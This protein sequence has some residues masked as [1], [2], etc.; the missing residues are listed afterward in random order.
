MIGM[1]IMSLRRPVRALAMILAIVVAPLGTAQAVDVREVVSPGGITAWLVQ[2]RTVPV[3]AIEFTFKGAGSGFDPEGRE[4]TGTLLAATMDEGAGPHDSAAFQDLLADQS[5]SISFAAGRDSFSGSFYALNRY[6]DNAVELLRLALN[7]PRFDTEPV[8]RVRGQMIVGLRQDETDPGAIASR[9]L[10]ET[11]F[12]GHPYGRPSDGT[13]E[14]VAAITVEDLNA[15]R[16]S[17]LTKD[18][19]LIGVVGD[20]T[21]EEL[22][23]ILDTAFGALPRT[24]APDPVPMFEG[25]PPSGVVVADLDVPQSTIM[26]AQPGLAVDDPRYYAG[27]VLNQVLG[28]G[29]FNNRLTEEV[30]IKRGLAYSVYSFQHAMDKAALLR[31]GAGTQNA[32]VSET[33][34]VIRAVFAELKE[35]GIPEDRIADAKTFLTGS[36]P[37]RFT[38]SSSIAGQLAAMRYHGFGI[39]YIDTRNDILEAVT[40][41]QVNALAAELLDPEGLLF[42]VVGRPE[43][44]EATLP[45]PEG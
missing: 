6:R 39:D 2:D 36:Y 27:M 1:P 3:T 13:P 33:L 41:E 23:P 31:G 24:G 11:I 9:V 26:F 29:S 40:A 38:S 32:R 5:I 17:A 30:R 8:E 20:I 34:D 12:D 21:P 43:G 45:M 19:L 25:A 14:S 35:N 15:Y 44:V 42:V 37:L 16:E 28:G 18:R 4:G 10:R 7:E 22:A